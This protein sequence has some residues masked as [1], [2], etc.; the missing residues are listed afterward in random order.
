MAISPD[1]TLGTKTYSAIV[2]RP[3][4]TTR[5]NAAADVANPENLEISHETQRSGK[6]SSVVYFDDLTQ[7][8]CND[9]CQTDV[10]M[11]VVRAMFKLQYNPKAGDA[12]IQMA[13]T[14]VI[15]HLVL[16][17]N[18]AAMMTKFRNREH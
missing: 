14:D 15:D 4:S 7:V 5:A 8:P 12:D 10:G 13:I 3:N 11:S 18:D 17:L 16:F 1:I 6:V 2:T 9:A